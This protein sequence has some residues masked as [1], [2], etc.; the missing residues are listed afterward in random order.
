MAR[1]LAGHLFLRG[2]RSAAVVDLFAAG[3]CIQ[4]SDRVGERVARRE[5]GGIV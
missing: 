4:R 3:L 5:W 1:Q 2:S